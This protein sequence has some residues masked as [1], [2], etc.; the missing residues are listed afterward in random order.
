MGEDGDE[1]GTRWEACMEEG[2]QVACIVDGGK[3]CVQAGRRVEEPAIKEVSPGLIRGIVRMPRLHAKFQER[4]IGSQGIL[5]QLR[6][7]A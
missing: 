5:S 7:K 6:R 2:E 1:A 4:L 3:E